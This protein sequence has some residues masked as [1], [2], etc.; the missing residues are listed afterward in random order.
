MKIKRVIFFILIGIFSIFLFSCKKEDGKKEKIYS[1]PVISLKEKYKSLQVKR[2]IK[3]TKDL[4][5]KQIKDSRDYLL[6]IPYDE[7]NSYSKLEEYIINNFLV[8]SYNDIEYHKYSDY[9]SDGEKYYLNDVDDTIK[10]ITIDFTK[11]KEVAYK[12]LEKVEEKKE[13]LLN[14]VNCFETR[15]D[16]IIEDK[17]LKTNKNIPLEFFVF[18]VDKDKLEE[19]RQ[20]SKSE[21]QKELKKLKVLLK[22]EIEDGKSNFSRRLEIET[23]EK[24]KEYIHLSLNESKINDDNFFKEKYIY[25]ILTIKDNDILLDSK[26]KFL[27]KEKSGNLKILSEPTTIA[28]VKCTKLT[29]DYKS[30]YGNNERKRATYYIRHLAEDIKPRVKFNEYFTVI[31][32]ETTHIIKPA[33]AVIDVGSQGIRTTLNN[34]ANNIEFLDEESGL[35]Y[36]NDENREKGRT[37]LHEKIDEVIKPNEIENISYYDDFNTEYKYKLDISKT[38]FKKEIDKKTEKNQKIPKIYFLEGIE[39]KNKGNDKKLVFDLYIMLKDDVPPTKAYMKNVY[40]KNGISKDFI[41]DSKIRDQF[42]KF[43]DSVTSDN[44]ISFRYDIVSLIPK[45]EKRDTKTIIRYIV[46]EKS[47]KQINSYQ[48]IAWDK[49]GEYN[50]LVYAKDEAGNESV[51]SHFKIIVYE[52]SKIFTLILLVNAVILV[53][54]E[55]IIIPIYFVN[56]K[57][58]RENENEK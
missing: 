52:D 36:Y 1:A 56:K 28:E 12:E 41:T 29:Y 48:D 49:N 46:D 27:E 42:F 40:A 26:E 44:K 55:I 15:I 35:L 22:K 6:Y 24:A 43:K 51:A 9:I 3:A 32:D 7:I 13:R 53:L 45:E 8:L 21:W 23:Y 47:R 31:E 4:S 39:I 37:P 10:K 16:L 57:R 11:F 2:M 38:P 25:D 17:T 20:D 50:I 19:Q 18:F 5:A 54:G 33:T 34:F 58:R 14:P 30:V